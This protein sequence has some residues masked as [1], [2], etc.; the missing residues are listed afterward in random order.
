MFGVFAGAAIGGPALAA[1]TPLPVNLTGPSVNWTGFDQHEEVWACTSVR[2]KIEHGS[3]LPGYGPDDA[4][5]PS[6]G[7]GFDTYALVTVDGTYVS[8]SSGAVDQTGNTLTNSPEV[9][10]GVEVTVAHTALQGQPILRTLVRL[11]NPTG[12]EVTKTVTLEQDLG[13]DSGTWIQATSSGDDQWTVADRWVIT[14]EGED[15]P[16][17][18]P[19]ITTVL[20]GPGMVASP[21]VAIDLCGEEWSNTSVQ[22][23]G[24]AGESASGAVVYS[25]AAQ[26][27]AVYFSVTIPAGESRYLAFFNAA[28]EVQSLADALA[29][30]ELYDAGLTGPLA[31]GLDPAIL[32]LVVNWAPPLPSPPP[33]LLTPTFT[34]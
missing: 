15:A 11:H 13:S 32:P 28:S 9:L 5:V 16:F 27:S 34:G 26:T 24:K 3:F 6:H 23:Q 2:H 20:F 1:S 18:D 31:A 8:N 29:L 22:A 33:V 25:E 12:A 4:D 17:T 30:T 21:A 7:D 10:G 14:T 19:V